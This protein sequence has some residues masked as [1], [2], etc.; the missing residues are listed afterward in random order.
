MLTHVIEAEKTSQQSEMNT[1]FSLKNCSF[2]IEQQHSLD[3]LK[4]LLEACEKM[5]YNGTSSS[6]LGHTVRSIS[7]L[8]PSNRL[9]TN[10]IK[11]W[12]SC[13]E[14]LTR[15]DGKPLH[16]GLDAIVHQ[17]EIHPLAVQSAL[18]GISSLEIDKYINMMRANAFVLQT[19]KA[20]KDRSPSG[21]RFFISEAAK[22]FHAAGISKEDL[23]LN[24]FQQLVLRHA[25]TLDDFRI[26]AHLN[27]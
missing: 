10:I 3:E 21:V 2:W 16:Q 4:N 22:S 8:F 18:S 17:K 5:K 23:S 13:L 26:D 19:F 12:K 9:E 27:H 11:Q 7:S 14:L 25:D 20:M 1:S 15:E 24:R 6:W